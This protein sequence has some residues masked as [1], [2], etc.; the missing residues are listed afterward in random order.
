[1]SKALLKDP[2]PEKGIGMYVAING[3]IGAWARSLLKLENKAHR[4]IQVKHSQQ[5]L[6][7]ILNLL[8]NEDNSMRH[9]PVL[10]RV[11]GFTPE[12][13]HQGF[14]HLKSRRATG[15]VVFKIEQTDNT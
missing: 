11:L 12:D 7:A 10:D 5:D 9:R 14:A 4:L 8:H 13:I 2:I 1:M 3:G 6:Q 15:K